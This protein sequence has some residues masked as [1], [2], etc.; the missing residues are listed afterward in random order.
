MR[1]GWLLVLTLFPALLAAQSGAEAPQPAEPQKSVSSQAPLASQLE[2]F[3][4]YL[5]KVWRADMGEQNGK[6]QIDHAR[7]QRAL[8]GQAIK[9]V[10]SINQGEY[11]G[12]T[13]IFWDKSKNSLAYYYFTTAG[14][15]THGTMS[16]DAE[17]QMLRAEENVENNANGITMV[18]S[19]SQLQ[20]DRLSV[21]SE[22]LQH[23]KW[24]A[25]HAAVYYP[26]QDG[27]VI[28]R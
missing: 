6:P 8:N 23:G 28:F 1:A 27:E 17:T 5:D 24:V 11:G 13:L 19:I 15:Y 10:H 14:F 26:T 18:R 21:K 22:Y 20:A 16:F 2:I 3:R 12:E 7:W 4:P 25:G 9:S